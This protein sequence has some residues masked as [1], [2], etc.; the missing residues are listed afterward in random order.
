MLFDYGSVTQY[1]LPPKPTPQRSDS[2][3]LSVLFPVISKE[4]MSTGAIGVS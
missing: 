4:D 1:G 2:W 3:K